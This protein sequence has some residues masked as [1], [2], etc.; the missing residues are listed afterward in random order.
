LGTRGR[1]GFER[2]LLGSV[3]EKVLRTTHVPVLTVPQ[4]VERPT[5]ALYKTIFFPVE[6]TDASTRALEYALS[7]AEE[8]DARLILLHVV[9][10]VIEEPSFSEI[11]HLSVSEYY[12]N[13]RDDARE[14]LQRCRHRLGKLLLRRGLHYPGQ[15]WT[16]AHGE[17]I[18]SLTW[19]HV[20]ERA[21]VDDYPLAIDHTEA[22]LLELDAPLA[23]LAER[24]P[25]REPVGSPK[26]T[27]G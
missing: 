22:R 6:F 1:S 26:K 19:T 23:E 27:L 8:T 20:A 16:R 14:D 17:W 12:R 25:Y 9:E 2:L 13:L 21:V 15:N 18:H 24:E 10:G 3:T 11:G 4:P 5:S 7:P